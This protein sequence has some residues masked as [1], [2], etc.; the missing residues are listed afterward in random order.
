M[1]ESNAAHG[2]HETNYVRIYGILLALFVI[3]VLGPTLGIEAVTLIT[4]F[5]LAV[6]K[7]TMVAGYFM[8]LNVEKRYIWYILLAM[9]V[10]ILVLFAGVAPD[11]MKSSGQNW[12]DASGF[13][14]PTPPVHH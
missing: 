6:V 9:L 11:V 5:G 1:S 8:H 4:A 2:A 10:F 14:P 7:A 12:R 13:V 3:S